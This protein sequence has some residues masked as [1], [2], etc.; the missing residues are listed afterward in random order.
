MEFRVPATSA[1][2]GPGFDSL[3]LALSLYNRFSLKPSKITSIQIRGEG[4]GNPKL[5]VDNVFVRIFNEQLK[6][7]T[8]S[9]IPFKFVF[10]NE[11]PI[12]RGLGSSSAVIIGAISAAFK[13]AQAPFDKQKILNFALRYESHPDNITPACM[14]GFNVCMLANRDKEVRFINQSLP[15]SIAAVV[16]IPNQST[17]THLSRKTL[18]KRYFQKD[19]VFNLSHA[20]LLSS[21]F[22]TGRFE[23]LREASQDRF[24]QFYRMKQIPLLFEIQRTALQN[25]ALMSTLSGSGSSFFSLCYKDD[26]KHL[27]YA[28]SQKFSKLRVLSLEF[29]NNGV[30]FED[31]SLEHFGD[32][33][34][35]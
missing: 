24:H 11:I 2:L 3:G 6:K 21:A 16:V 32:E 1:N 29:D 9:V 34:K 33:F 15:D 10:D 30:L 27:F 20:S 26:T 23:L 28:L 35:F 5:R 17:S 8:G 18:P 14:G 25:G 19:A 13:V 4:S 7:L 12:S 22:I 31:E